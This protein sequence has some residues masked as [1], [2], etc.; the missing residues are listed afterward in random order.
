MVQALESVHRGVAEC[1]GDFH[2]ELRVRVS[3]RPDGTPHANIGRLPTREA[4]VCV[5]SLIHQRVRVRP[6]QG[7]PTAVDHDYRL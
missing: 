7:R 2:G 5:Q 4:R 3:F 6:F 1:A